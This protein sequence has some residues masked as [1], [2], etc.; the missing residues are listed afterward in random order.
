MEEAKYGSL[1][2]GEW[3]EKEKE[4]K[5]EIFRYIWISTFW[6]EGLWGMECY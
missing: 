3:Q 4:K 5:G 2:P 1:F 6:R